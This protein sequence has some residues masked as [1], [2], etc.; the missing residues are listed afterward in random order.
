MNI[1]LNPGTYIATI[2]Y[3]WLN[4]ANTIKGLP[5]LEA[6]DVPMKY[7]DDTKFEAKLLD[8]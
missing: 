4:L 3:N 1:N 7:C 5:I 6:K 8:G 2:M